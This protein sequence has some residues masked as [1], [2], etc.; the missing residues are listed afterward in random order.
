MITIVDYGVG[1]IGALLNMF[2]YLGF[3]AGAS[4]DARE[5]AHAR[6]LL[7]PGVGAFDKAMTTL[8]DRGL[9][10][11]LDDAV[12]AAGT[13]ILGVC[14]G[15]QLL[16]RRSDEGTETGLGWIPAEV[17]RIEVPQTSGLKIPH[18]GWEQVQATGNGELFTKVPTAERFYFVHGYHMVCDSPRDVAATIDYGS[19][20]ACAVQRGKIYGVQF[21][22]EKSHR[23]GMRLLSAFARLPANS[24]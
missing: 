14:L 2:E 9:R 24:K 17:R 5:I 11:A 23:F 1:N 18:I 3:N 20:L 8:R 21:H 6:K 4:S 22:P 19:S 7:L 12:L 13:P 10:S 16:A 15:M